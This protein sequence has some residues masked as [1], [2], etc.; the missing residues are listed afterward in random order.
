VDIDHNPTG[1]KDY[2]KVLN[3]SIGRG[4]NLL[5]GWTDLS[6]TSCCISAPVF[7]FATTRRGDRLRRAIRSANSLLLATTSTES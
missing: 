2:I 1:A 7:G 3:G 5:K 4:P 6:N